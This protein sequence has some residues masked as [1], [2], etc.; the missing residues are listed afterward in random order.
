MGPFG[1]FIHINPVKPEPLRM[2][3]K[4]HGMINSYIG[5]LQLMFL[6][7]TS[8]MSSVN[9]YTMPKMEFEI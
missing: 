3:W 9:S 5:C 2:E 7:Q 1:S 6:Q 8:D 4:C